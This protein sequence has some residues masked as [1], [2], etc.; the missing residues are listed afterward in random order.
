[1]IFSTYNLNCLN[2]FFLMT[3]RLCPNPLLNLIS[4]KDKCHHIQSYLNHIFSYTI[5]YTLTYSLTHSTSQP[6]IPLQ[7]ILTLQF[8]HMGI[9]WIP[10]RLHQIQAIQFKLEH[11]STIHSPSSP[12][13]HMCLIQAINFKPK[14]SQPLIHSFPP[15]QSIFLWNIPSQSKPRLLWS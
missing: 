7:H 13:H 15:K 1:M 3:I 6:S 5:S 14:P 4:T 10:K 8:Q 9:V 12:F 11:I 2:L